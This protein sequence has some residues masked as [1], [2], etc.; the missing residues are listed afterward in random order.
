MAKQHKAPTDITVIVEEKGAFAQWIETNWRM[1]AFAAIGVTALILGRSIM[2]QRDAD[3]HDATLDDF[4]SAF[5]D[6][7]VEGAQEA[8]KTLAGTGFE[9]WPSIL[10][11]QAAVAGEDFGE[12]KALLASVDKTASPLFKELE[13]PIG[14]DGA[15]R[16]LLAQLQA[17][18]DSSAAL[19]EESGVTTLC[20]DPPEGST[21]VTLRTSMGDIDVAFFDDLAPKHV[22]NFL[23]NVDSGI[24]AGTRFHRVIRGFMIQTGNPNSKSDSPEE[25]A[26]VPED[27]VKVE[28]EADNGLVHSPYV[29]AAAMQRGETN[30]SQ[31]QFY[32]TDGTGHP[33][34]LDGRHT[35][36][37]KVVAGFDV[38]D[39][40]ASVEVAGEAPVDPPILES[41]VRK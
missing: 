1:L 10:A 9:G 14:P 2:N 16:T 25:W 38:V 37:G 36:Y 15:S 21:T 3:A 33:H 31:F 40:I 8:A 12:A 7:S 35:V 19:A 5:E 24:Y 29:L 39:E 20:P 13:F 23:A 6:G 18:I 41:V 34:H 4:R 27:E 17:S 26:V 11:V 28:A 30:S 32:I 22:A